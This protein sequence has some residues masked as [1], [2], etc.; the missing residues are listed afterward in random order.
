M[1]LDLNASIAANMIEEERLRLERRERKRAA[2]QMTNDT[3]KK[4]S[5]G[6]D[7]E[8]KDDDLMTAMGFSSFGSSKKSKS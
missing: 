4:V 6:N 1:L 5:D 8:G 2:K 3:S 7:A